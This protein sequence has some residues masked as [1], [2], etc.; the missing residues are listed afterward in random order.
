MKIMKGLDAVKRNVERLLKEIPEGVTLLAAVKT[1]SAAEVEAAY[2]AGIRSF[3]HNY[4]Q[5]AQAMIPNVSFRADWHL[6]GH[7][8][9][10]K[11]KDAVALFDMVESLDSIRLAEELER[12]CRE[13]GKTMLVLVEV[14][15]GREENKTGVLPEKVDDLVA[16]ISGMEQLKLVGLMTMGPFAGDPEDARPYFVKTRKIFERLSSQDIPNVDMRVLS[17]G[18]SNSYQVAVEEGANL[19]RIG[20]EIFGLRMA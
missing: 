20:T 9:R 15:S 8:Q 13:Q 4:V 3:G 11:A 6:I 12:R 16:C 19:V 2:R 14:N 17:M 1:R 10:N 18:M 7:L 5:E